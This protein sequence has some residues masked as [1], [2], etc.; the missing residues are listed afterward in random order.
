MVVGILVVLMLRRIVSFRV[1]TKALWWLGAETDCALVCA[2]L[3][4]DANAES[5]RDAE[6]ETSL[7]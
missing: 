4:A 3:E 6:E 7:S 2:D 5:D 1:R